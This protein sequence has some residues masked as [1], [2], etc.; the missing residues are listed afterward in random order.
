[1]KTFADST[2]HACPDYDPTPSCFKLVKVHRKSG[3]AV[4]TAKC[5][6]L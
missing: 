6:E 5:F 3:G 2:T 1:M 4:R